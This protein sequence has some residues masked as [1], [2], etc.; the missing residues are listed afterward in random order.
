MKI[1]ADK[2]GQPGRSNANVAG[3]VQQPRVRET[4][5]QSQDPASIGLEDNRPESMTQKKL[6]AVT[7]ESPQV[8][9]AAQLQ[10]KANMH[11]R[12]PGFGRL[13]D[14]LDDSETLSAQRRKLESHFGDT[15]QQKGRLTSLSA[16]QPAQATGPVLQ[17][18]LMN[19]NTFDTPEEIERDQEATGY[20]GVYLEIRTFVQSYNAQQEAGTGDLVRFLQLLDL[21]EKKIGQCRSM[22]AKEVKKYDRPVMRRLVHLVDLM[23]SLKHERATLLAT[24]TERKEILAGPQAVLPS[25]VA[26][27][28]WN[29]ARGEWR[30]ATNFLRSGETLNVTIIDEEGG[31]WVFSFTIANNTE[32]GKVAKNSLTLATR[33]E[34]DVSALYPHGVPVPEDVRQTNLGDCYLQAALAGLAAQNPAYIVNKMIYDAGDRVIVRLYKLPEKEPHFISVERSKAQTTGGVDLYNAG[35]MWVKMVQKAYAASGFAS[36]IARVRKNIS[37][38][39]IAG[40]SVG[41]LMGVLTGQNLESFSASGEEQ[42]EPIKE[43]TAFPW[44]FDVGTLWMYMED[45]KTPSWLTQRTA[46]K[47]Y[48]AALNLLNK[49]FAN[50]K[51]QIETWAE[52]AD[53][54]RNELDGFKTLEHFSSCFSDN[55]LD[56]NIAEIMMRW[57]E[58]SGFYMG[59]V[60]SGKYSTGQLMMFDKIHEALFERK[61]VSVG[62]KMKLT[63]GPNEG[64]GFSG[65]QKYK[66]LAGGHAYSVLNAKKNRTANPSSPAAGNIFWIQLRNP[67]GEYSRS[68]DQQWNPVAIDAGNGVFWIELTDLAK[69]FTDIEII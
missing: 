53:T 16:Q 65:E 13:P 61:M 39:D 64:E 51:G 19:S 22:I 37:I 35:A 52:F 15:V 1:T 9:Q 26:W 4:S 2:D 33:F 11:S 31:D 44:S 69:N 58:A 7:N 42:Q 20:L 18:A 23:E 62:T 68:Y 21:I 43:Q 36:N 25:G 47:E 29:E 57:V 41:Y 10:K 45:N 63:L 54:H 38:K 40:D 6:Q 8:K 50:N 60:G 48:H 66:G 56:V 30:D 12:D 49:I 34:R 28:F 5:L 27:N 32:K 67:W 24:G 55:A 3:P 46:Y 59:K 17:R 14:L